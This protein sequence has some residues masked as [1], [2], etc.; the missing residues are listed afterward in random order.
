MPNMTG[1]GLAK[2]KMRIR[3]DIPITLCTGFN[4]R[5]DADRAGTFGL[6]GFLMKP[7]I[8]GSLRKWCATCWILN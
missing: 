2:E 8:L 4:E 6:Q 1:M 7:V 5:I 3:P